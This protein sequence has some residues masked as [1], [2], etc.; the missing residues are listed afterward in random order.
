MGKALGTTSAKLGKSSKVVGVRNRGRKTRQAILDKATHILVEDGYDALVLRD[1]A[2]QVGIKLGNLQYYFATREDLLVEVTAGYFQNQTLEMEGLLNRRTSSK[3]KLLTLVDFYLKKW[4]QRDAFLYFLVM[5]L[6]THN[7]KIMHAKREIYDNFYEAIEHILEDV[8]P[9]FTP[10]QRRQKARLIT[11]LMDGIHMQNGYSPGD[12][13]D[14]STRFL[15][16]ELRRMVLE[17]V[18]LQSK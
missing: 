15:A 5:Q 16:S 2:L 11:T 8:A 10:L 4:A 13:L 17:I 14:A 18:G 1:L 6:G 7:E 9:D 12:K 3:S